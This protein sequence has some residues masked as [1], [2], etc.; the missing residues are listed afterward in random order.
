MP[1]IVKNKILGQTRTKKKQKSSMAGN[2]R[3]GSSLDGNSNDG[4]KRLKTNDGGVKTKNFYQPLAGNEKVIKPKVHR[5]APITLTDRN[6]NIIDIAKEAGI[7]NPVN[8]KNMTIGM[9][10]FLE[11]KEDKDKLISE[12]QKRN[13]GCFTHPEKNQKP[14]K[15]LLAGLPSMANDEIRAELKKVGLFPSNIFELGLKNKKWDKDA[16]YLLHFPK[17]DNITIDV[18]NK[19]RAVYHTIITWKHYKNSKSGPTQCRNCLSYGHGSA[20]CHMPTNC[21]FCAE[22]HL[23]NACPNKDNTNFN[24]KC[25]N[26]G[27]NHKSN[28]A[29]CTARTTYMNIR[30]NINNR[31]KSNNSR[32]QQKPLNRDATQQQRQQTK[33]SEGRTE[34]AS[35]P[36]TEN[37]SYANACKS[38][39]FE[40]GSNDNSNTNKNNL[41]SSKEL[42]SIFSEITTRMANCNSK[43][44]QLNL[45]FDIASK[46]VY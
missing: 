28:D 18:L 6:V 2:K 27:G 22:R 7:A 24:N 26:C 42:L 33:M 30:S 3:N 15:F 14:S 40:H 12:L 5:P 17:D 29:A 39:S 16:L 10:V 35:R 13:V 4:L 37:L 20:F 31:N 41:F 43:E 38:N 9:K 34:T 21:M 32:A 25:F 19:I 36:V 23:S 11:C 44:D 46:Y 8:S 45:L 1:V